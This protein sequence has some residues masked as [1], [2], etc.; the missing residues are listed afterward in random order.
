[1]N[2]GTF[3]LFVSTIV[4][5]VDMTFLGCYTLAPAMNFVS[6]IFKTTSTIQFVFYFACSRRSYLSPRFTTG[7]VDASPL[8]MS[9]TSRPLMEVAGLVQELVVL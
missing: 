1:M 8:L 5:S 7:S 2:R 9:V 6:V 3:A 4:L